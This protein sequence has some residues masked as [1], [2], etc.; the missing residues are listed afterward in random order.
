VTDQEIATV[1]LKSEA[2]HGEW[3]YVIRPRHMREL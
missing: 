1:N 3:N 2:F